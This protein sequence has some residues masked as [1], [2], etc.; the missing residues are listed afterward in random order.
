ME[1]ELDLIEKGI[2]E[3]YKDIPETIAIGNQQSASNY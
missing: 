1:K 3:D 2:L